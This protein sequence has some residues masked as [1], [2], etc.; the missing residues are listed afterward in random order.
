MRR[1]KRW[2]Q[3]WSG[4]I[5]GLLVALLI[6]SVITA[7]ILFVNYK[8]SIARDNAQK[9]ALISHKV[10]CK[11]NVTFVSTSHGYGQSESYCYSCDKCGEIFEF[12][13]NDIPKGIL[14]GKKK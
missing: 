7:S 4:P 3:E 1:L 12:Y 8:C 6:L 9:E 5:G 2:W 10:E 14:F 13:D 11:G